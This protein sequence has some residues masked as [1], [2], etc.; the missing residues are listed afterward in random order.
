MSNGNG[1]G[2]AWK[3]VVIPIVLAV[4]AG[5]LGWQAKD[6]VD[7]VRDHE[8]RIVAHATSI[9]VLDGK[10]ESTD[11]SLKE[12]QADTKEMRRLLIILA[13]RAGVD[14]R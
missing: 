12:I 4:A 11:A 10:A 3:S 8:R 5:V 9:T 6:V 7:A 14:D 2:A 13:Q 1:N